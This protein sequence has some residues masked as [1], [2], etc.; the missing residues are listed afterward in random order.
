MNAEILAV[1]T[2]LLLG[3]IVNTNAQY[4]ARRLADIGV[5]VYYQ[6]VVGDNES[7]LYKSFELALERAD[8][9]IT[10][11]GLGPTNDDLTK[12]TATAIAGK[13]LVLDQKSLEWI[14]SYFSKLGRKMTENNR[15]Q[16]Y[17]PEGSV[18]FHN[19]YGTAPGCAIEVGKKKII[20]LPGPPRE[21]KPMFENSVIPYLTQFQ[22]GVLVSKVL[23]ICGLGESQ[24]VDMLKDII[25]AQTNPTIAPYAKTG[26][27]TLRITSKAKTRDEAS[28]KIFPV[29]EKIR[30]ILGNHIYGE[31]ED[32]T[33]ESVVAEMLIRHNK[34]I[35]VAESCTGGLLAARLVN[36]PGISSVFM[37]GAVTYSNASKIRQLSV[38][39]ETLSKYG[40]VSK[41]TAEEMAKG[42]CQSAGTD[43]GISTTGIAG[44]GGGSAEKPV[45]LVYSGVCI[46]GEVFS[47]KFSFTGD[48]QNIRER[49]VISV[50]DWVRRILSEKY[51]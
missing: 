45:G 17:F 44:P 24:V 22:D 46:D 2:E 36:Y 14:E 47:K 32:T 9:V 11:G 25:D 18:I 35:A 39:E 40:A 38:K 37:E 16:A 48:R 34:T 10:T 7:R 29:E 43:I 6:S 15:K 13:P 50:L 4:I 5:N 21:M 49:T 26:E 1:G 23:R 8:I 27:V 20:L 19:E 3:D 51:I 33:L 31:G 41:E 30:N 28:K 12:E 42:I